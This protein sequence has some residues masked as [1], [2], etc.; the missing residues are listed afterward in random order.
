MSK[1]KRVSKTIKKREPESTTAFPNQ[2]IANS[3]YNV[4]YIVEHK[5]PCVIDT[6][7]GWQTS[8]DILIAT[9]KHSFSR[10]SFRVDSHSIY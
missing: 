4:I 1:S 3:Y 7:F 8:S 9:I 10:L 6:E 5:Y 2:V